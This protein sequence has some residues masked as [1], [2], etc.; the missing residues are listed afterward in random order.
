MRKNKSMKQKIRRLSA[1]IVQIKSS[2]DAPTEPDIKDQLSIER[3]KGGKQLTLRGTIALAIR[4]NFGNAATADVG[5]M[6]LEDISRYTVSRAETKAGSCLVA[7]S[8]LFYYWLYG[9]I[10][11]P[12]NKGTFRT[13]TD[14][15]FNSQLFLVQFHVG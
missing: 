8:R 9:E 11:A 2:G 14:N 4:R 10:T 1:R 7:S 5:A 3:T 15:S 13:L 6:L 12:T